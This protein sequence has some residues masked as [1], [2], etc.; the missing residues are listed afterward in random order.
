MKIAIIDSSKTPAMYYFKAL[1]ELGIETIFVED[2]KE[3][4]LNGYTK[5][6]FATDISDRYDSYLVNK[7]ISSLAD[8][9]FV[10]HRSSFPA[11]NKR[12]SV[13]YL[14]YAVDLSVYYPIDKKIDYD[15]VF[16][17]K[18]D[19]VFPKRKERIELL[20]RTLGEK[21]LFEKGFFFEQCTEEY[22]KAKIIFNYCSTDA[23][24]MRIFEALAC[25]KLLLTNE[26]LDLYDFFK[27]KE[28][29]VVYHNDKEMI[30]LI[31]YYSDHQEKRNIIASNGYE[32]VKKHTYLNRATEILK[33]IENA[34]TK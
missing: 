11:F 27:D 2:G 10:P 25:K 9:V 4:G 7:Y 14:P 3:I 22:A 32:E 28:H 12:K 1:N 6:C 29:L 33:I 15:V 34:G 13:Y 8:F 30:E 21:F 18:S 31:K 5:I 19:A 26:V 24:N 16:V 23:T 17:G 20:K